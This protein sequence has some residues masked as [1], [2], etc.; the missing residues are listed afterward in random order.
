MKSSY[1]LRLDDA[2]PTMNS[3][4]WDRMELLLN[5]YNVRPLVGI[6]PNC[7][8]EKLIIDKPDIHFWDKAERWQQK[9]WAIALHGYNHCYLSSKGMQGLNPMWR[10]SEFSG[11]T[12]EQQR[13]KIRLGVHILI[14]HGLNPQFFFAPSHTF[15]KNTLLALRE[16]SSIR[17]ISDTIGFYPYKEGDFWFI[18]Q[19]TGHCVK[20]PFSG[21]YT[22][23]FHPNSMN[24][25]LFTELERFLD[26]YSGQFIGFDDIDLPRYG[27]KHISDKLLSRAFFAS[28]K[29]RGLY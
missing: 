9:G 13:N 19:I 8:D 16:E 24:D 17:I 3:E 11:L 14:E 15:D 29:I 1:L 5:R 26:K 25:S 20:V 6:V 28:R 18:P 22:F 2:C 4:R 23:C 27:K 12:L 21:I 7:E 10:R